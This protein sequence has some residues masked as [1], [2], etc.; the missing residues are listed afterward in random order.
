MSWGEGMKELCRCG[1]KATRHS[2]EG[3]GWCEKHWKT[4]LSERCEGEVW[5]RAGFFR[6]SNKGVI[7][8]RGRMFCHAHAKREA[9]FLG[10]KEE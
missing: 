7:E 6:C 9:K 8:I 2:G 4:Y 5:D 10:V 3:R 1:E